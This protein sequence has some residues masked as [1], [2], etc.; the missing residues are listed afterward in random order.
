MS[1]IQQSKDMFQFIQQ[2][3]NQYHIK[4]S[5]IEEAKKLSTQSSAPNEEVPKI[6]LDSEDE[7]DQFFLVLDFLKSSNYLFAEPILNFESQLPDVTFD[8]IDLANRLGLD[9]GNKEPLLI[10]LVRYQLPISNTNE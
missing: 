5:I 1:V 4:E 6:V 3:I 2:I 9:P 8:R 7:R 10:Q